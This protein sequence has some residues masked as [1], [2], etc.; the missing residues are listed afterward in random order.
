MF[1]VVHKTSTNSEDSDSWFVLWPTNLH[2]ILQVSVRYSR[3]QHAN[4]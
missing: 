1:D 3:K 4:T 2:E